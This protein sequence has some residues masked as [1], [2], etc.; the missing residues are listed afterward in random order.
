[1][2]PICIIGDAVIEAWRGNIERAHEIAKT[3]GYAPQNVERVALAEELQ[4]EETR[5]MTE[6]FGADEMAR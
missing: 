1:M 5:L 6:R 4:A 3:A 2:D